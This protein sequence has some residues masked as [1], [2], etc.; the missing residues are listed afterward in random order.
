M[1]RCVRELASRQVSGGACSSA[2]LSCGLDRALLHV[3]CDRWSLP[4][5]ECTHPPQSG[6]GN[7]STSA[8]SSGS[9]AHVPAG[10]HALPEAQ[11]QLRPFSGVAGRTRGAA[12]A[13]AGPSA[14][15]HRR[16]GVLGGGSLSQPGPAG[17]RGAALGRGFAS[18][19][20]QSPAE[21]FDLI[22][23]EAGA[24]RVEGCAPHVMS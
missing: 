10:W 12:P 24:V 11:P 20:S 1:Q 7:G 9:H 18:E 16:G 3:P 21:K 15:G 23:Q 5:A 14:L 8:S 2:L 17:G 6:S 19:G 22:R 13:A 4:G